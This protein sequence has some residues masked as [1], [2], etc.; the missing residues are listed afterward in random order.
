MIGEH[1][2][3]VHESTNSFRG[4]WTDRDKCRCNNSSR[5]VQIV[6][7]TTL[8]FVN[9]KGNLVW[10]SLEEP[11]DE[12]VF[13]NFGDDDIVDFY[14]QDA[15]INYLTAKGSLVRYPGEIRIELNEEGV[16][17]ACLTRAEPFYVASGWRMTEELNYVYLLGPNLRVQNL[18]HIPCYYT[19]NSLF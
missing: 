9:T 8:Y 14:V 12:I 11:F 13:E 10:K 4:F 18:L 2:E 6:A 5:N 15:D 19:S 16:A 17:W 1:G 7:E 3:L